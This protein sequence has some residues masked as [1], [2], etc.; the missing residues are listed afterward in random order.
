MSTTMSDN[1]VTAREF[2]I[3]GVGFLLN[4]DLGNELQEGGNNFAGYSDHSDHVVVTTNVDDCQYSNV[5]VSAHHSETYLAAIE[6]SIESLIV[7]RD[8]LHGL[9]KMA[10]TS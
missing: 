9:R 3:D 2:N 5:Q 7:I 6:A 10:A 4:D 1:T 8:G